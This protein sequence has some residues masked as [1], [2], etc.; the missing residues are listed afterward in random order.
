MTRWQRR[1]RGFFA[2]VGVAVVVFV[3]RQYKGRQLLQMASAPVRTDPGA[4]VEATGGK[5]GKFLGSREDVDVT[6]DKQLIYEDGS[7]KL[8][9]VTIVVDEH[10]GSRT[11]TI[12]GREGRIGKNQSTIELD[13]DIRLEGSDGM[14]LRTEHATYADADATVRAPGAVEYARGRMTGHGVGMTWDKT[15]DIMQILSQANVKIAP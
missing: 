2:I 9:G 14:Q 8:T 5:V 10:N 15:R 11:F 12:K 6:S 7:S 4:V 13:G 3:A 1:A